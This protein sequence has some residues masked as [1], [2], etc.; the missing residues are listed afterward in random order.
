ME[1]KF[2]RKIPDC[3]ADLLLNIVSDVESY[4]EFI[5]LCKEVRI[6]EHLSSDEQKKKF[7]ASIF[8]EYKIFKEAF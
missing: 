4:G 7:R 1:R 3:S 2:Q 8:I 6:I 5:P